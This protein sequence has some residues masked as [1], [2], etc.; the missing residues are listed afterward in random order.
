MTSDLGIFYGPNAGYALD[1]YDQY[2]EDPASVD[3]ASRALFAEWEQ[4]NGAGESP[5]VDVPAAP[6]ETTLKPGRASVMPTPIAVRKIASAARLARLIRELGHLAAHFNPLGTPPPGDPALE[7]GTQG[8]RADDL[9]VL[10]ASVVGGPLAEGASSALEAIGRLRQAYSGAV[11]YE[12]GHIHIPQEREWLRQA[13]ETRRFFRNITAD[14]KRE[15]LKRLTDV[16]TFERFLHQTFLGQKRFSIEGLDMLVPILDE[17]IRDAAAAGTR[18]VVMGMAHRGRLNVLAHILGKPYD[19]IVAEFQQAQKDAVPSVAGSG[20]HGWSGDVKYH[21]GARRSYTDARK[22]EMPIT[23]APNPSHLEFVDPVV[24][25]RARA[26]QERRGRRGAPYQDP[27]A[28]LAVLIHGDAAFPGQGI[29]AETLNM[30]Q[31]PGYGVGGT[32]HIITNNQIG[33]TTG[34][35]DARSTLYASDLAKGFEIPIVHVNADDPESCIAIAR[36]AHAYRD[37]FGKDFLIDLVGYRRWGHNEGDEPAYTQPRMY[38]IVSAHPT[39]RQIWAKQLEEAHVVTRDE[40]EAMVKTVHDRLS[41]ARNA[42]VEPAAPR[43]SL[44]TS[45]V[46]DEDRIVKTAVSEERLVRLNDELLYRSEG[47]TPNAKLERNLQTRAKSIHEAG[48]IDWAHAESLAFAS[49]LEDATPIRFTGQDTE[50]G[51]FSQRHLVLH[52]PTTGERYVPLQA[53]V[54]ASA[55]F[56]LYNSPLSENSALGFEYGYS[57]HATDAMVLWEAQFG[58]F[59]NSAQVIIDQFLISGHAKWQQTPSLVLLLPHGYEGQ[60]P[61]HSSARLERFLQLAAN[62]NIRVVN[63]TTSAQYFHLLR[64]Q[65]ALLET[66]PKPL[67]IL[68]PKSLLRLPRAGSSLSDLTHGTFHAVL[69]DESAK[70]RGDRVTRAVLCSGKVYYD[71]VAS[72]AYASAQNI[73]VER[74]EQLYPFPT[75][76]IRRI[77]SDFPQLREVVWLQ[78]EPRNMGAWTFVQPR[79]RDLLPDSVDVRYVG[80]PESASPAEGSMRRHVSAQGKIITAAVSAVPEPLITRSEKPRRETAKMAAAK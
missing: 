46:S 70:E 33:F 19:A 51:T 54:E 72:E 28:S 36:M 23:L 52:D 57:M 65:A 69:E 63:C 22:H 61:E 76:T 74:V 2:R 5:A 10:P 34:A 30:S 79:L 1:L 29:V 68:T 78:E 18:E 6:S 37:R 32:I 60:G 67:V 44:T 43:P 16:E 80:R 25:G 45:P 27:A 77:L 75:E 73:A 14:D 47:F 71:L 66:D 4:V 55:S 13:I 8:L 26:A 58:D 39:V 59:G 40:T 48:G 56:A 15:V 3:P 7:L 21:L 42:P 50:R 53:L 24:L 62:D 17:I 12:T 9:A 11:G 49:I 41:A 20:T 64:R 35:R 31:L 38:E